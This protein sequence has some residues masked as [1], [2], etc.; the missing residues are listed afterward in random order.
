MVIAAIYL[1]HEQSVGEVAAKL[2][3]DE[4]GHV[5]RACWALSELLP[6]RNALSANFGK[7]LLEPDRG[8]SNSYYRGARTSSTRD[9]RGR[10]SRR[11]PNGDSFTAVMCVMGPV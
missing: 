6:A 10:L 7:L 5:I 2:R 11:A 4:L 1:L 8:P 3:P 9:C